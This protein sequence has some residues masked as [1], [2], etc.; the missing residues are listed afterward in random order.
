[1]ARRLNVYLKFL[2]QRDLGCLQRP[3]SMLQKRTRD[4]ERF[5]SLYSN[6]DHDPTT[7]NQTISVF[8][9]HKQILRSLSP[10]LKSPV[11]GIEMKIRIR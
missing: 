4:L 3:I 2:K 11:Y 10:A 6:T 7:Q 9:P 1:M 5:L 8:I